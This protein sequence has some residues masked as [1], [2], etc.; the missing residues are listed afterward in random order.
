MTPADLDGLEVTLASALR[1]SHVGRGRSSFK[2][3]IGDFYRQYVPVRWN[4]LHVILVNG[5]YASRSDL[6]PNRG[7]ATDLWKRELVTVFGGGCGFWYTLYIV[8]QQRLATFPD[9][10]YRHQTVVCNAAK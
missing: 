6:F 7:I 8:E 5:F 1:K 4:G 3:P 2:T 10:R 9:D